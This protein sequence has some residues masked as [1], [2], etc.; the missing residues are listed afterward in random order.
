MKLLGLLSI[1]LFTV[2]SMVS[3]KKDNDNK[4]VIYKANLNG[5]SEVP[6]N[7]SAATGVATLTFNP[8]T[9]IFSIVVTHNLAGITAGHIH[10]GA[11]GV[12]GDAVFPFV[13]LASPI[14]FTSTALNSAQEADLNAGLYYVNLHTGSFPEGEI[15]GQLIKQ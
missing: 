12:N 3:C 13:D 6:S 4:N 2:L 14:N 7:G 10:R 8:N 11:V 5:T 15:R 1:I 9:K